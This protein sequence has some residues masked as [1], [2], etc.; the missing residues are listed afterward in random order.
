MAA[1]GA[2][3]IVEVGPGRV[4][5]KLIAKIAPDVSSRAVGAP[6]ELDTLIQEIGT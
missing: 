3:T 1:D 2:R 6:A 5:T 4:L